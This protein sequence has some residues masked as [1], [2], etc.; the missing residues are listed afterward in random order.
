MLHFESR[1]L[2]HEQMKSI[3]ITLIG[4]SNC[5]LCEEAEQTLKTVLNSNV[6]NHQI[7]Q[8]KIDV[9]DDD[10]LYENYGMK[11]PVLQLKQNGILLEVLYWPF[12]SIMLSQFLKKYLAGN[13]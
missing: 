7:V 3:T 5:H 4:T 8:N 13:I 2:C 10:D 6:F 9:I 1:N 11:I 12:D